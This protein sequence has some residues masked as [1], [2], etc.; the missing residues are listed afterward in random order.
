MCTFKLSVLAKGIAVIVLAFVVSLFAAE[1]V[2]RLL[3][4]RPVE[5]PKGLYTQFNKDNYKFVPNATASSRWASGPFS[6]HTDGLG[7]RCDASNR[8]SINKGQSV[9][10]LFIGDSQ[11]FG[12]GVN[13]EDSIAGTIASFA[14]KRGILVANASVE[15]HR[16]LNQL[17]LVRW[18]HDDQ[19]VKI[20]NY[21]ILLTPGM[22][23]SSDLMSDALVGKDGRL[24]EK[25]TTP[26]EMVLIKLKTYLKTHAMVYPRLRDAVRNLNLGVNPV[27]DV[28]FVLRLYDSR[29]PQ[30][31][32]IG[33]F[34]ACLKLYCDLAN[35]ESATVILVYLPLT[36][37]VDFASVEQSAA[38]RGLALDP[39]LPLRVCT[40]A[41]AKLNLSI[42]NVTPVLRKAS[43]QGQ[44]LHL[45][46]D[47]HYNAEISRA[48][49]QYLWQ[50]IEA[51]V[52]TT[53]TPKREG[54]AYGHTGNNV[55]ASDVH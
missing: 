34:S 1:G 19:D 44:P 9:G 24:Y 2:F 48:C 40:M 49:A 53:L 50:E 22:V 36:V 12:H 43:S 32:A 30:D 41:A 18:L 14:E 16:L 52:T 33:K 55:P 6:I 31:I 23:M 10:I 28:P 25:S 11:G 3:G 4:D 8:Y 21:V 17:A 39:G 42:Y 13:F 46:G 38:A 35:R 51:S 37:E 26:R 29:T 20:N 27:Q 54:F 45:K 15:G 7:L 5:D 47:F